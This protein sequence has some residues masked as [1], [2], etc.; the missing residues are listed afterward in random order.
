MTRTPADI[1]RLALRCLDLTSLN[2]ND[3]AADIERLCARARGPHGDVAAVC[4]W[5]RFV[6]LSRSLLPRPARIAA[7]ANFPDGA[8]DAELAL[9]DVA[10]IGAADGD[11]IDLVLPWRAFVAGARGECAALVRSVRRAAPALTL[12]LIIESGDLSTPEMIRGACELGLDEGVDFLKTSTGK[13]PVSATPEAARVM[14]ETIAG[15]ARSAEVGFKAAGGIRRVADAAIYLDLVTEH[16]GGAALVPERCRLGAS[17]L[18][19]D[20]DA[21]LSG[22]TARRADG[23]Y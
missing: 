18:L 23:D 13:R 9:R 7:V 11:E 16:L 5:P 15:H 3:S 4:V 2:D 1:A 6:A 10:A 12:K 21:V 8:L 20:I 17:S 19:D 22:V 14:L